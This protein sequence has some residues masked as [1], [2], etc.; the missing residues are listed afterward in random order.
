MALLLSFGC[1]GGNHLGSSARGTPTA[2]T[3]RFVHHHLDERPEVAA[4]VR[5]GDPVTGISLSV[6]TEGSLQEATA[7][8]ALI[9]LRTRGGAHT[10]DVQVGIDSIA[11]VTDV[12]TPQEAASAVALLDHALRVPVTARELLAPAYLAEYRR[13]T[14]LGNVLGVPLERRGCLGEATEPA[15]ASLAEPRLSAAQLEAR[16]REAQV[17]SRARFGVVGAPS[18]VEAAIVAVQRLP[19]WPGGS[20]MARQVTLKDESFVLA[21]EPQRISLLLRTHS[22]DRAYALARELTERRSDLREILDAMS[23]S[24]EVVAHRAVALE[25][26][27]CVRID[28]AAP[29]TAAP[30]ALEFSQVPELYQA[31]RAIVTTRTVAGEE[32][33]D[34]SILAALEQADP[35]MASK[36]SAEAA[37][38]E[39]QPET[40]E[41]IA[42]QFDSEGARSAAPWATAANLSA[43][44]APLALSAQVSKVVAV[45]SG[46]G[47]IQALLASPCMPALEPSRVVGSTALFLRTLAQRHTGYLGV[48][49]SPWIAPEGSG[50]F[51][52]TGRM[53]SRESPQE[54]ADRLGKA[55]GRAI[56]RLP[57]DNE[58]FW[59]ERTSALSRLGGRARPAL[60][61]SLLA[62]SPDYPGLVS[63]E[64]FYSSVEGIQVLELRARARQWLEQDL[65][66]AVLVNDDAATAERI[67]STLERYL[68]P[69]R[70]GTKSCE[71]PRPSLPKT[72]TVEV[73]LPSSS[74]PDAGLT[75]SVRLPDGGEPVATYAELLTA[76]LTGENGRLATM[77]KS[78]ETSVRFDAVGIGGALRRGLV[79]AGGIAGESREEDVQALLG[80]LRQL[81]AGTLP[82]AEEFKSLK[83]WQSVRRTRAL[84]DPRVR[85]T[86]LWSKTAVVGEPTFSGF[87]DFLRRAFTTP[88]VMVVRATPKPDR[89][90]R[91][92]AATGKSPRKGSGQA[93]QRR[94]S[95]GRR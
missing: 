53:D 68:L 80:L 75:L 90:E 47:K 24:V 42:V 38:S 27:G 56:T 69:Y 40:P 35:R 9:A 18:L 81:S 78:G 39:P 8:A 1:G 21:T 74:V 79:V 41:S 77:A 85:L 52:S 51:A 22:A 70:S 64:G 36:V 44:G 3:A 13:L 19:T 66:L 88:E 12:R 46:Q 71:L 4:I 10:I 57:P 58:G 95:A 16:R 61:T 28:L 50:L 11:M 32:A 92:P 45:E 5:T 72:G 73:E 17:E 54:Q 67:S 82:S 87:Q 89:P 84:A 94:S 15:E 48:T 23:S 62:L 6:T 25:R 59:R 63:P 20:A 26:G 7:L 60:D 55:L 86:A 29:A 91:P 30:S 33:K 2:A 83:G 76:Y 49:L 65:R 37:R 93:T 43:L 34:A 31:L 14:H